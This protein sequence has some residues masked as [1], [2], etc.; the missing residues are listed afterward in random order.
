MIRIFLKVKMECLS[1]LYN[2]FSTTTENDKYRNR[3]PGLV[4]LIL[5]QDVNSTCS[6][7][8]PFK[9]IE[10]SKLEQKVTFFL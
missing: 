7:F 5:I 1:D 2:Y 4:E 8:I 9:W 3:W 10:A 6:D